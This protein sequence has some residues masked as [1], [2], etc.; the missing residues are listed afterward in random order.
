MKKLCISLFIVAIFA[1]STLS[2]VGAA[3]GFAVAEREGLI[4]GVPERT[5][6]AEFQASYDR[7]NFSVYNQDGGAVP[8][9]GII[10]TGYKLKYESEIG[11]TDELVFMVLGDVDG[12]GKVTTTDYISIRS[13]L[14]RLSTLEGVKY[15]AADI[16]GDGGLGALDYLRLKLHFAGKYDIYKNQV[17]P[18]E[19]VESSSEQE[20]DPWTSGWA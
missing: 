16:D 6:L 14:R 19:K 8:R 5:A 7:A 17:I 20:D 12:N 3:D 4:Y 9:N 1:L 11:A 18:E 2:A 10:G 13:H 15:I